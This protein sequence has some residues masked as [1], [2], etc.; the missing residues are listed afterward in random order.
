MLAKEGTPNLSRHAMRI[1]LIRDRI[2]EREVGLQKVSGDANGESHGLALLGRV[3]ERSGVWLLNY[4][5]EIADAVKAD[6]I[7][8]D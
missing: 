1:K 4:P 5:P 2:R 3:H 7:P 6:C 8:P